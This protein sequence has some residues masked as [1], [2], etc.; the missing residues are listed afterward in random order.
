MYDIFAINAKHSFE[1]K[2][3]KKTYKVKVATKNV[4]SEIKCSAKLIDK[5]GNVLAEFMVQ[6]EPFIATPLFS[7]SEVGKKINEITLALNE[8]LAS[9]IV[10]L[11]EAERKAKEAAEKARQKAQQL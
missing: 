7:S 4:G 10:K 9:E 8:E 5:Q 11:A 3:G 2:Y 6:K 1:L